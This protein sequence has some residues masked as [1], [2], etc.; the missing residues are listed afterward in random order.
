MDNSFS[1]IL[2][3][4]TCKLLESELEAYWYDMLSE[5]YNNGSYLYK[6]SLWFS[7]DLEYFNSKHDLIRWLKMCIRLEEQEK[8]PNTKEKDFDPKYPNMGIS[9]YLAHSKELEHFNDEP[10]ITPQNYSVD[11]LRRYHDRLNGLREKRGDTAVYIYSPNAVFRLELAYVNTRQDLKRGTEKPVSMPSKAIR[12]AEQDGYLEY[13]ETHKKY[14][15]QRASL[16]EL[17]MVLHNKNKDNGQMPTKA[18]IHKWVISKEGKT[19]DKGNISRY[20]KEE[21]C[22]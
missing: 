13:S 17:I 19:Y 22:K 11:D 14:I 18:D 5:N 9:Y 8:F 10:S 4:R 7:S 21:G 6:L 20:F 12:N 16:H 2:N 3:N 1:D 15:N